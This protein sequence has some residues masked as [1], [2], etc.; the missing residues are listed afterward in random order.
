MSKETWALIDLENI[1]ST[2]KDINLASY[3]KVFIFVGAKQNNLS[4]QSLSSDK[5]I[6]ITILK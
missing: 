5:L 6:N 2:L 3:N 1:G 4:L